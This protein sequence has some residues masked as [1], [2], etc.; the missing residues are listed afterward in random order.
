[1]LF[2][3]RRLARLIDRLPLDIDHQGVALLGH[4]RF[5]RLE[6]CRALAQALERLIDRFV[7]DVDGGAPHFDRGE[8]AGIKRRHHVE[9]RLERQRLALFEFQILDVGC[10]HGFD[11]A[12]LK[13]FA[14][15]TF[16]QLVRDVMKDLTLEALLDHLGRHFA[17][18]EARD[19]RRAAVLRCYLVDLRIDDVGRNFDHQILAGFVDVDQLGFHDYAD[20]N[21]LLG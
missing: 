15:R 18:A 9:L 5:H 19:A 6:A 12:L 17:W 21:G 16:D 4:A 11:T 8:I 13:R 2:L 10:R 3:R 20:L 1:M 14:D 7:F